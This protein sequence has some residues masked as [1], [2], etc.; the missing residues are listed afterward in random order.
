MDNGIVVMIIVVAL[1]ELTVFVLAFSMTKTYRW[2]DSNGC[3]GALSI[4]RRSN[5]VKM[6]NEH[7]EMAQS[8][9][10]PALILGAVLNNVLTRFGN[11]SEC[12]KNI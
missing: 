7:A 5:M 1:C 2:E 9:M 10:K 3:D 8:Q 6:C 12:H 11:K 4:V